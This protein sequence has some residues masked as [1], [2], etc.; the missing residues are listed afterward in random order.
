MDFGTFPLDAAQLSEHTTR[1]LNGERM[2]LV[3]MGVLFSLAMYKYQASLPKAVDG[4][5]YSP[6]KR[7]SNDKAVDGSQ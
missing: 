7:G 3:N 4:V 1:Y 2:S 5:F 6:G